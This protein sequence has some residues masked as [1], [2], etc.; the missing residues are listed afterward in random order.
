M[1]DKAIATGKISPI[2]CSRIRLGQFLSQER[3]IVANLE[4]YRRSLETLRDS[5][6]CF[7]IYTRL[8][9]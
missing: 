7:F 8:P 5:E 2:A 3:P 9:P 6:V 4:D 1:L